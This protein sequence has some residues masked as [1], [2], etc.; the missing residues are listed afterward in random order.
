MIN[1]STRSTQGS[2]NCTTGPHLSPVNA[3]HVLLKIDP[4]STEESSELKISFLILHYIL[5]FIQDFHSAF[6][7]ALS[8]H[9]YTQAKV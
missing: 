2:N 4:K 7:A 3:I 9:I 6:G 1:I 8:I 5:Q